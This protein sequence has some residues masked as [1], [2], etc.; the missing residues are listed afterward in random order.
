MPRYK[1]VNLK[2]DAFV[3]IAFE[4][5]ILPGTFEYALHYLFDQIDLS[6]FD[7]TLAG[8]FQCRQGRRSTPGVGLSVCAAAR[9]RQAN[10]PPAAPRA[11]CFGGFTGNGIFVRIQALYR[12]SKNIPSSLR[13]IPKAKAGGLRH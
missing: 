8:T 4:K 10:Y 2:Q 13:Q 12:K 6:A 1:P 9:Q 3:P 5:Q 11:P 7:S